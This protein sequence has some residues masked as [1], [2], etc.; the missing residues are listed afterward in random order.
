MLPLR[1]LP[2]MALLLHVLAFSGLRF[3]P[4]VMSSVSSFIS[5]QLRSKNAADPTHAPYS[6]QN[7]TGICAPADHIG[8]VV[9]YIYHDYS[10]QQTTPSQHTSAARQH[11]SA[12]RPRLHNLTPLSTT[13]RSF[14]EE[15]RYTARAS[16]YINEAQSPTTRRLDRC[17]PPTR[18]FHLPPAQLAATCNEAHTST[19]TTQH[20]NARGTT[21]RQLTLGLTAIDCD[22]APLLIQCTKKPD[23]FVPN[24]K[25]Q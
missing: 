16:P 10:L 18:Q 7:P 6:P 15:S 13:A 12:A 25:K 3:C 14:Q 20:A 23:V 2:R 11:T 22:L 21:T 5:S 19:R 4:V 1:P 8:D 24:P 9:A 17:H